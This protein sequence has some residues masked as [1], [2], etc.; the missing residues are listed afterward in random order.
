MEPKNVRL[1]VKSYCGW[2]HEAIDWLA[3][4]GIE[5][6]ILE[7]LEDPKAMREMF[8][9]TG[10]R[11]TP[12]MEVDGHWLADFDVDELEV[13]WQEHTAVPPQRRDP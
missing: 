6:E 5:T 13:W 1:F 4:R 3:A 2:C 12:S 9:A 10:Q 7:V 11:R 8:D